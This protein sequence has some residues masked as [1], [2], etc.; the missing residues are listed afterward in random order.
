MTAGPRDES[1]YGSRSNDYFMRIVASKPMVKLRAALSCRAAV[2]KIGFAGLLA[3]LLLGMHVAAMA[4]TVVP[5]TASGSWTAPPGVT[6]AT[7]EAWGGGGAGGGARGRPAEGGGGAGGQYASRVVTVT[8]GNTYPVVVGA[9]GTGSTGD[10]AAGGDS[11]FNGTTVVA[12]GGAGGVGAPN[13]NSAGAAGSG[14]ASNGVGTT[15]YAGGSGSSGVVAGGGCQAGGAG[16]GGAGSGGAGG[17]ASG[18]TGG[19]GT[20][21]GGGAGGA[22]RNNSGNGSTGSVAGGGGGAACAENNTNRSGGDGAAGQVTITYVPGAV[23]TSIDTADPNP[24]SPATAVSWAVTFS[25]SVTGVTQGNFALVPASGVTGAFITGVTP[26]SGSSSTWTVTAN[27]GSGYGTLGLNMINVAGISPAVTPTTFMGQVY[28]IAAPLTCITD[29]FSTGTLDTSL[30]DVKTIAG[31]YLPQVI[32]AGGGDYRLRLTDTQNNEATFAQLKRTFPAAGNR[33]VLEFDYL[34]YGGSGADGVAVTFS[35]ATVSSTT[36]GFGGSLGYAQNTSAGLSGFGGGWLGIGLDEYGNYPCTNEGRTGYPAGWSDPVLGVVT[37]CTGSGGGNHYVAIRGSGSGTTGYNL[38][39]N[40]GLI[41]ATAPAGGAAGATPYRY[42][43]TLDHSDGVHAYVTVERDITGT[44]TSYTTLVPKFDAK[45]SSV[46]AAVPANWLISFT[47]S[48]G[49]ATNNHEFKRVEVCANTI[50]GSGPDHFAVNVGSASASTCTPKNIT[51]SALDASN[52]VIPGYTGTVNITTSP[53]HGDWSTVTAAGTLT[54]GAADS[55]TAS[56]TFA[57]ADNGVTT[58]A[59]SDQHA[60]AALSVS[61]VDPL[62]GTSST[63]STPIAFSD[64]AFVITNDAVQ[65]AGRP[66]AMSVAM[67]R[68]DPSTGNCSISP[69]YTGAKNLK[70]WLTLDVSDPGGAAP[71]IGAVSL[72]SAVPGANNLALTFGAGTANFNLSTSDVGKYALNLRDDSLSFGNAAINGNSNTI[73]TRPF[74]L[75]VS[76]IKQGATNNLAS[77]SA[78]GAVFAKAGTGFQATVGAYLWNSAADTNVALGDGIP[79]AGATLAQIT[80][81]GGAPSYTWPTTVSGN[82]PYTPAGGTLSPLSSV[83]TG[84]CPAAAPNCFANG[85]ATPTNLSY[86]EVGSF[87]LGVAATGYL[88]TPGVDLTAANGTALVFD[89]TGARNGVVG[90]FIP[91]HFNTYVLSLSGLPML[92]PPGLTC[93]VSYNGFVYSG[94]PFSAQMVA[95]N[96]ANA[97]TRNYDGA[98]GFSKAVTLSA[99]NAVGGATQNPNGGTFSGAAVASTAF[100]LGSATVTGTNA[101]NYALPNV[102][103]PTNIYIRAQDTDG[104]TSLLAVPAT[105]IEGGVGVANGRL[106]LF[107]NY[108]SEKSSLGLSVQAQYWSGNSWILSST[109]STTTIPATSVALSNYRDSAGA[110]TGAW[111][112]S[113]MV[114]PWPGTLSGGQGTLPLSAPSPAGKTGCVDVA[115]NLGTTTQDNS[116]L[117]NHPLMTAPASSLAWLRSQNGNCPASTTYSAD[118]SAT[119]CFGVYSPETTRTIHVRELF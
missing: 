87:T 102:T 5:F 20:A 27:T 88:N 12:K 111:T 73:T 7:V 59:L 43:I 94:E 109:D 56:Y 39:A 58:L 79:D 82:A 83:Q 41:A 62:V 107:N 38:L 66:Q 42:R 40:T 53:A 78:G 100:S 22:G 67:W 85:I 50:V 13:N 70:A 99:W 6:S 106:R 21:T 4:Q 116:C 93:P 60:D 2:I 110:P 72:P 49:G 90:R 115:L 55:G 80:A 48:T 10:G 46:Q 86:A 119:A 57:A 9:G 64:N 17:D 30:W 71:K 15:V 34:S 54:P 103:A 51:I 97:T 95:Q 68:K 65:V 18:N 89:N 26:T 61:V 28:T 84:T 92:C 36:G 23:V 113:V 77:S 14:T 108:G 69:Y 31:P 81:N 11:T 29:D 16:G 3:L 76:A 98:L 104:V 45:A 96:A 25:T 52:N 105:S 47:G 74:A 112:T 91:D 19:S 75:V 37:P 44:G 1:E 117:A 33:V 114:P 32:N 35:D 118:P 24:S 101:P 8:P 63:T